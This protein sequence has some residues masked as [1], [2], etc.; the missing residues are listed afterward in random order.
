[1]VSRDC[2]S[3]ILQILF[4]LLIIIRSGF[5][6]EIRWPVCMSKS[7]RSLYVSLLLLLLLLLFYSF[8]SFSHQ[9][10]LMVFHH[11]LSDSKCPG[12]FST[13]RPIL[14]VST[15]L[16]SNSSSPCTN[17][18]GIVCNATIT[19]VTTVTFMFNSYF[20][21]LARS[22][23][24]SFFSLASDFYLW[25]TV[26]FLLLL[27]ITRSIRLSEIRWFVCVSFSTTDSG[28]CIYHL[29]VWSNFNFL[30]NSLWITFYQ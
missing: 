20:S 24:L 2:K 12:L 22:R 13:V 5:Q 6:A 25:P 29:F 23:Y 8:L 26:F 30:H 10:R 4:L 7:H 3:T 18:L 17:P 15:S 27:T 11:S 14:M 9:L 28:L 16:L 21:S 1:M 19:T